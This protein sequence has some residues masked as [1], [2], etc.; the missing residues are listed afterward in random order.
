MRAKSLPDNSIPCAD[1]SFVW[2]FVETARIYATMRNPGTV[3]TF[4]PS[5]LKSARKGV[6]PEAGGLSFD[7]ERSL[8]YALRTNQV[9]AQKT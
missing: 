1:E 6:S 7:P 8:N 3:L 2:L 9:E 4:N 5:G